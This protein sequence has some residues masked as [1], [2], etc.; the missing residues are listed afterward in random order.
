MPPTDPNK[1]DCDPRHRPQ[2]EVVCSH[3]VLLS[4]RHRLAR[5]SMPRA[6]VLA[7]LGASL[8]CFALAPLLMPDSYSIL[9]NAV[10]ESAA[11]GV[12]NAWLARTG[13]LL[14]GSGVLLLTRLNGA[15]WGIWGRPAFRIYGI[16]MIAAAAFS[17]MPWENVPYDVFEDYLHSVAAS[18]VGAAFTIGVA[19]VSLHRGLPALHPRRF[20]DVIAILAAIGISMLIFNAEE[21]AGLVQRIMFAIAYVWFALEALS[22]TTE[23]ALPASASASATRIGPT[24]ER[25]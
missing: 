12:E 25:T 24:R 8:I 15:R 2:A 11:Q 16:A 3:E 9:E 23:S 22:A 14:F 20:V 21:L 13:F 7:L 19:L 4:G 17:H 10:S 5:L 1:E 6:A 18:T